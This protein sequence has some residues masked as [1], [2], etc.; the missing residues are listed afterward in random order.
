M[1]LPSA[2]A[3][4]ARIT[5]DRRLVDLCEDEWHELHREIVRSQNDTVLLI[6]GIPFSWCLLVGMFGLSVGVATASALI[7]CALGVVARRAIRRRVL[8]RAEFELLLA[9]E[10]RERAWRRPNAA[11]YRRADFYKEVFTI[12]I[13]DGWK[14]GDRGAF[15]YLRFD[16]PSA[17]MIAAGDRRE[18]FTS[19]D[20]P[21]RIADSWTIF[22]NISEPKF[23]EQWTLQQ[24][25]RQGSSAQTRSVER[26]R[27]GGVPA[28]EVKW[29]QRQAG[30]TLDVRTLLVAVRGRWIVFRFSCPT[31]AEAAVARIFDRAIDSISWA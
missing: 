21:L 20:A 24:N 13:P 30:L 7:F 22:E 11:F 17:G 5:P 27:V 1:E 2:A 9:P 14:E 4:S 23:I 8:R 26:V 3:I 28:L 12:S 29:T 18:I 19:K 31:N 16:G 10:E 15:H 25:Q 6:I